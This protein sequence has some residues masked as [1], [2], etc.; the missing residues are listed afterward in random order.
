L[1]SPMMRRNSC[2]FSRE[3]CSA[4]P[5]LSA[6]A[7]SHG[8]C[9]L[10]GALGAVYI[11]RVFAIKAARASAPPFRPMATH[12]QASQPMHVLRQGRQMVCTR[13]TTCHTWRWSGTRCNEDAVMPAFTSDII[14]A[15]QVA[16]RK[17]RVPASITLAQWAVESGSACICR[18]G[19]I[20]RSA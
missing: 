11:P 18:A 10:F 9:F 2:S 20:I 12:G 8:L 15:A 16:M 1:H 17:W 3:C 7:E 4:L 19:A 13:H 14:N 6:I 5:G